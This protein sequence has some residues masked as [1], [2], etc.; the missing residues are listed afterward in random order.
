MKW[1]V[2]DIIFYKSPEFIDYLLI[3]DVEEAQQRYE[4]L[5]LQ[6]NRLDTATGVW[7]NH[8]QEAHYVFKET[9]QGYKRAV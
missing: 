7:H 2:G 4:I 9:L 8:K 6:T 5:P 3:T 1:E